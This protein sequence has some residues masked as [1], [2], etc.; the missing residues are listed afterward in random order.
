M[1]FNA[2]CDFCDHRHRCR[3]ET[4]RKTI[5]CRQCGQPFV[6]E[7]GKSDVD[8]LRDYQPKRRRR[9]DSTPEFDALESCK[10]SHE[11][12]STRK[13]IGLW[14]GPI[15]LFVAACTALYAWK[16]D[17]QSGQVI[18]K[19]SIGLVVFGS[20]LLLDSYYRRRIIAEIESYGGEVEKIRWQPWQGMIGTRGYTWSWRR[21]RLKF[22]QVDYIDRDNK[23]Q[24]GLCGISLFWGTDW[25]W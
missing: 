12:K 8:A 24:S 4:L 5:N 9:K 16:F 1:F 20:S 13:D 17:P 21:R 23:A 6:A 22:Y 25:D 19:V 18:Y 3:K 10:S 14:C 11:N 15:I 7:P 2:Y